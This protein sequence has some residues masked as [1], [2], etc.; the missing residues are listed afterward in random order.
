MPVNAEFGQRAREA[1]R[2]W[3]LR[4]DAELTYGEIGQRTAD[5]M[6][7]ADPFSHQAVRRWFVEGQEPDSFATTEAL[8]RVL[9]AEPEWL[10]F[11][12]GAPPAANGYPA[13]TTAPLNPV[14]RP[15]AGAGGGAARRGGRKRGAG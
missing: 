2:L 9:E 11:G 14:P 13:A 8:A 6:G 7:R 3:S 10:A 5:A 12:K 1:R 4:H 15:A